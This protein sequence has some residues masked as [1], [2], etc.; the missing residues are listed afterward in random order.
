MQFAGGTSMV[1]IGGMIGG[2]LGI[3][4]LKTLLEW[5]IF[6]RVM[7]DPVA[8][9]L[10][11]VS[12]AYVLAISIYGYLARNGVGFAAL[13]YFPGLLLWAILGYVRGMKIRAQMAGDPHQVFE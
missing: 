7:S 12:C 11:A 3:W 10:A 6:K 13:V 8:G 5:A 2:I 9:K 4:I 1:L